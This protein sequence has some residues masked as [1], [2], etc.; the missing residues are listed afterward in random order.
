M[1]DPSPS[2]TRTGSCLCGAIQLRIEGTPVRTNL[3]HCTSCQKS[4]GSIF[5][6]IA[7]YPLSQVTITATPA[8]ALRTYADTSPESGAVLERAFCAVCGCRVAITPRGRG[9]VAVPTGVLDGG[10]ADLKP[11]VELFCRSR[12]EWLGDLGARRF[13]GMPE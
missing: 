6:S 12:E 7:A 5:A 4:T 11:A 1:S 13:E 9:V 3:C 2:P 10:K 8:T